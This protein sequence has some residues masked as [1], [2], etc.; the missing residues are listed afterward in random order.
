MKKLHLGLLPKILIAIVLGIL[1]SLFFPTWAVRVFVTFNSVF[2]NFLGMFIPLLIIGLIAP[3][4]ADLGKGAGKLLLITIA[5]AYLSTILAGF[6]SYFTCRATYPALLG[7][8]VKVLGE[9]DMAGS[10][11]PFFTIEMP[12]FIS[13][14]TALVF[15][16]LLGLGMSLIPGTTLNKAMHD[17]RGVIEVVIAKFIIPILPLYIFG[18]FLQL[19]AE[20]NVGPV[21]GTF[22]KIIVIIVVMHVTV[23]LLQF[24]IA[25]AIAKKNPF[26][27]LATM[28]S[29]YVT[30]LGTQSSAAT[31]P[32]TLASAKKN[33]VSEPVADFVIPLCATIHMPCSILKI[34]ACAYAI[35]L[36]MGLAT[37]PGLYIGFVM[38]LAITMVAAPG[39][40]GGAIMASLGLLGSM[41]G[42]DANM[43][44]LMIALYIAMDSFGTAGNVTGDGA[45]ALIMD[46]I[47]SKVKVRVP[48]EPVPMEE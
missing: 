32:V 39:V 36:G 17:F 45:I 28:L 2:G 15:A 33:G 40:P 12:A 8:S 13:V 48:A 3:A 24:L 16:F 20:G 46:R 5:I 37:D 30:A 4:I 14:T 7:S 6:F 29:A 43:Q 47:A 1:C 19:G 27:S 38:M 26:R 44:G 23:L 18:I 9:M 31:I 22:A 11:K 41:L 10:V 35:S 21:L 34:T 25:G 42:F